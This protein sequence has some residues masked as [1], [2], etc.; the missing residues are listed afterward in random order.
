MMFILNL[1]AVIFQCDFMHNKVT[2]NL[3]QPPGK[4]QCDSEASVPDRGTPTGYPPRTPT[5]DSKP[6]T[7]NL[8][9]KDKR[10]VLSK[11][12]FRVEPGQVKA[13]SALVPYTAPPHT[14]NLHTLSHYSTQLKNAFI[15][16]TFLYTTPASMTPAQF[17]LYNTFA[18]SLSFL[19]DQV[20]SS[21]KTLN[22]IE[23]FDCGSGQFGQQAN[24]Q[25]VQ[26][27]QILLKSV[28]NIPT[29]SKSL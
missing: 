15:I 5:Q 11:Q 10:L 8:D 2:N 9:H 27:I 7:T 4:L 3:H 16:G 21:A 13:E 26:N 18:W 29:Q 19:N 28:A 25:L 6:W 24:K 17:L 22:N 12:V 14:T 20:T 23:M 1:L